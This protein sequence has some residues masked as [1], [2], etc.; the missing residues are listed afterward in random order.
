[1]GLVVTHL[2]TTHYAIPDASWIAG[3]DGVMR[4]ASTRPASAQEHATE[5]RK[6]EGARARSSLRYVST[7]KKFATAS[8][9][10]R[11]RRITAG[12]LVGPSTS[13]GWAPSAAEGRAPRESDDGGVARAEGG[14]DVVA[15]GKCE[16]GA[17]GGAGGTAGGVLGTGNN[18]GVVRV[19]SVAATA[20]SDGR[21][22]AATVEVEATGRESLAA[23]GA[24]GHAGGE[25]IGR[26]EGVSLR[27]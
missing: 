20:S 22:G 15:G 12:K 24:G 2:V 10:R 18:E 14:P 9:P 11:G 4:V 7:V 6:V 17:V 21:V 8:P 5:L 16:E 13:A 3:T 1:M 25:L 27:E 26:P 23:P 19:E